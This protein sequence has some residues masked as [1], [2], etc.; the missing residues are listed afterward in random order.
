MYRLNQS[1]YEL[2][3]DGSCLSRG[4]GGF[5]YILENVRTRQ[6][7]YGGGGD[8]RTTAHR[9]E[10]KAAIEGLLKV[11]VGESVDLMTDN[12]VIQRF[13]VGRSYPKADY[14][15]VYRLW[16]LAGE[17]EPKVVRVRRM[18]DPRNVRCHYLAKYYT[19]SP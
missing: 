11:P 16:E 1:T 17:C 5:A 15:L 4:R 10:I 7:E 12:D 18:A 13:M 6:I 2:W 8:Y 3:T 9:M 19:R 14:D